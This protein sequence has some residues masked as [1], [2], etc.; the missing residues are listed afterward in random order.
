MKKKIDKEK[1]QSDEMSNIPKY[2][3]SQRCFEFTL[4]PYY[5]F[6][7]WDFFET[8]LHTVHFSQRI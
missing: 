3:S 1:Y 6:F 4:F 8:L 2:H 7:L 5:H